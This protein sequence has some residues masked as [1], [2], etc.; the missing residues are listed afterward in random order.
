VLPKHEQ[1][2]YEP[3]IEFLWNT[4]EDAIEYNIEIYSDEE[5]TEL[6]HEATVADNE[7]IWEAEEYGNYFW[8]IQALFEDESTSEWTLSFNFIYFIPTAI[9]DLVLWLAADSLVVA[10]PNKKVSQWTD[11]SGNEFHALQNN[12]TNQPLFI[13]NFLGDKPVVGFDGSTDF[14]TV[15]LPETFEQPNTIFSLW[16]IESGPSSRGVPIGGDIENSNQI[17]Y[18]GD[19]QDLVLWGKSMMGY[20]KTAPF[21][22]VLTAGVFDF[23]NSQI[24]ENSVLKNSGSVGSGSISS[25]ILIGDGHMNFGRLEGN[26]AEIVLYNSELSENQRELVEKYIFHKYAPPV[27]LGLDKNISYGFAPV[28]LDAGDNYEAYQWST[29]KENESVIEID[30]PGIYSVTVTDIFG[31]ESSDTIKVTYPDTKLNDTDTT[32]CKGE[33]LIIYPEIDNHENYSYEWSTGAETHSIEISEAGEYWVKI[34]D[35]DGYYAYSDTLEVEID[36]FPEKVNLGDDKDLCA[37]N[38][39]GLKWNNGEPENL[40]YLWSTGSTY[41]TITV[42]ESGT[43]SVTVTNENLC[44][45]QDDVH[46]TII[47][48]VPDVDF[49]ADDACLGDTIQFTDLSEPAEGDSI[50]SWLWD[51]GDGSTSEEQHPG[52]VFSEP[53]EY[54]VSLYIET[55]A[56]CHNYV[57]KT[58][59]VLNT[60]S[61]QFYYSETCAGYPVYFSDESIAPG[62]KNI[63]E[64]FWDFDD[65]NQSTEQNPVH[66]FE[67]PGN[68]EVNL[69]VTLENGCIDVYSDTIDVPG[70]L[71][72]PEEFTLV[73]PKNEQVLYENKIEFSWNTTENAYRFVLEI[74][75][76]EEMQNI[77]HEVDTSAQ[78]VELVLP[79]NDSYYWK[80]KAYNACRDTVK[81]VINKVSVFNPGLMDDLVLWLAADSMVVY[82]GEGKVSEWGDLSGNENN[83][84]QNN[85]DNKPVFNE[86][87]LNNMPTIEFDGNSFLNIDIYD[88]YQQPNTVF[89]VWNVTSTGKRG[90]PFGGD[91]NTSNNIYYRDDSSL[92]LHAGSRFGYDKVSPFSF[93]LTTGIFNTSNS[94]IFENSQFM[95]T[96]NS[97]DSSIEDEI[98]IGS[99]WISG[100]DLE[101][102]IAEIVFYDSELTDSQLESVE[103]YIFHK[104][105]PPVNLG[106]DKNFSDNFCPVEIDAGDIYETYLWSTG[107]TTQTMEVNETGIYSVT[108]TDIFGFE[109][110]DSLKVTYPDIKI[111]PGDTVICYGDVITLEVTG[112]LHE[113]YN[114]SWCNGSEEPSIEV[115]EEGEYHVEVIDSLGCSIT[116][117]TYVTVDMFSEQ[118]SLGDDRP[119]C[120][121]DE[122]GIEFLD[123]SGEY[124]AMANDA[125]D[126]ISNKDDETYNYLWNTGDTTSTIVIN[127]PGLYSVT[128]TNPT[129]CMAIDSV[130]LSFQGYMPEPA[131]EAPPVCFGDTTFFT[132]QSTVEG[133]QIDQW[134]WQFEEGETSSQQ[135]PSHIFQQPGYFDVS[136]EV[137]SS[138]GCSNSITDPVQVYHLPEPDY[139]PVNVCDS[140]DIH[141]SDHSTS[142]DGELTQWLWSFIDPQG[143]TLHTS[144]EQEPWYNFIEAGNWHVDLAV[145]TT[146]GCTDTLNRQINVRTSPLPD[147][148]Y[149]TAC[150]GEQ[151][152]FSDLTEAPPWAEVYKWEWDFGD[153]TTSSLANPSHLFQEDGKHEVTLTVTSINGCVK[154]TTK[155]IT[156]HSFPEVSFTA[157]D[158]CAG[159][160]NQ[161]I[162][163]TYVPNSKP[164]YW[165]WDFGGKGS[166]KEQNP[167][168]TF[169]EPG[170]YEINLTVTSEAGCTDEHSKIINVMPTPESDFEFNPRFGASPLTVQFINK[171]KGASSY[172]WN[173]DDGSESTSQQ[174]PKHTYTD[175]G[176]Y[177]PTLIAFDNMGCSDTTTKTINVVPV[178]VQIIPDNI[179]YKIL[180]GYLGTTFEFTNLSSIPLDT[181]FMKTRTNA[182]GPLR[183]KWTG[184]LKPGYTKEYIFLSHLPFHNPEKHHYL[185][186]EI[187]IPERITGEKHSFEN[188]ISF[189]DEFK[190]LQPYPN[191][192]YNQITIS[193]ILPYKENV[194]VEVFDIQGNKMMDK[195]IKKSNTKKGVNFTKLDL[196]HLSNGIYNFR[197]SYRDFV[198]TGKFIKL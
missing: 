173:F 148:E 1:V 17:Y 39:I 157:P 171:T 142:K 145:A 190:V 184:T 28:E 6:E 65:G 25:P 36:D 162:D 146:K 18:R 119:F 64:W 83:A 155:Y 176:E 44:S 169:H 120:I 48:T 135:H 117:G 129:G 55:A 147:F 82:D 144:Q 112:E 49:E 189:K 73:Y 166:S 53:G 9:D 150:L 106:I 23:S 38:E 98:V 97:G 62:N 108:V 170:Q 94:S 95:A 85:H 37:G 29:G 14:M 61:A 151:V 153:G 20:N 96:G 78:S 79:E 165:K 24:Y 41:P 163:Q 87:K 182:A 156:V 118:V 40:T 72:Y 161:F 3:E 19:S 133:S 179:R 91:N 59:T 152:F 122:L 195:E 178:S 76:D 46:I 114:F 123:K 185:C 22:F 92:N 154:D 7:Y 188:C 5:L 181:L 134:L 69:T 130:E 21:P 125:G 34:I 90:V 198:K 141:F 86:S 2:L 124:D 140:K 164:A 193:F 194:H 180:E 32:L 186:A 143:D 66:I 4:A 88:V 187:I 57:E 11:L 107:D 104:Y 102:N 77:I 42:Y 126:E 127:E 13:E 84:I 68:Y 26:I 139:S 31:F 15:E 131:F 192:A 80:V 110:S 116:L 89:V 56:E 45:G 99:S 137:T 74:A 109:S 103:E 149:S 167:W 81:S 175:D 12:E 67:A 168:F 111:S 159:Q 160:A 115:S 43:Y 47:G 70:S 50:V 158:L 100:S 101:G 35:N 93:I 196:T 183:E 174:N 16:N 10:N 138:E 71:P 128:V 33:T 136:L 51:F 113:S 121:G 172:Q 63:E 60:P 52:H 8:R 30:K 191:P 75:D 177:H 58:V 27:N 132:D 197:I 105:S 54:T